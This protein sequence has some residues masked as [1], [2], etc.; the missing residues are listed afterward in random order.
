MKR[1][2]CLFL[3]IFM[4]VSSFP[5]NCS[6]SLP[7]EEGDFVQTTLVVDDPKDIPMVIVHTDDRSRFF[8]ELGKSNLHVAKRRG[9]YEYIVDNGVGCVRLMVAIET[10]EEVLSAG[11][12]KG[13]TSPCYYYITTCVNKLG[14]SRPHLQIST[15]PI[16]QF[17]EK[18]LYCEQAR[19]AHVNH[20][21]QR[22]STMTNFEKLPEPDNVP[23]TIAS[24][25]SLK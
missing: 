20:F 17:L 1:I 15:C 3:A 25:F 23:L 7:P 14:A 18:R 2:F 21:S 9:S 6:A 11:K 4:V 8:K 10:T 12:V 22:I 19:L 13:S 5:R 24:P 16:L